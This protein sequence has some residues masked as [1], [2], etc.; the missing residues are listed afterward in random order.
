MSRLFKISLAANLWGSYECV[1]CP[2]QQVNVLT[3]H[4]FFLTH[5]TVWSLFAFR[6]VYFKGNSADWLCVWIVKD[7]QLYSHEYMNLLYL[8]LPNKQTWIHTSSH[9]TSTFDRDIMLWQKQTLNIHEMLYHFESV[10]KTTKQYSYFMQCY[11][12]TKGFLWEVFYH[13]IITE[14]RPHLTPLLSRYQEVL[15]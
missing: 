3:N 6:F 4:V 1:G 9:K 8:K 12:L 15:I 14:W 7:V 2:K 11:P 5:I 10:C 13:F